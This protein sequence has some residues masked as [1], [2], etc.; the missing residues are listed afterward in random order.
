MEM[1]GISEDDAIRV[2]A[3]SMSGCSDCGGSLDSIRRK[4]NGK[5]I[6]IKHLRMLELC[7]N[8]HFD[9]TGGET[10]ELLA[11][12]SYESKRKQLQIS[13]SN[14]LIERLFR[15]DKIVIAEYNNFEL[16]AAWV[17]DFKTIADEIRR[18]SKGRSSWVTKLSAKWAKDNGKMVVIVRNAGRKDI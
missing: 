4:L 5:P 9:M 16:V 14:D 18:Q 11:F 2:I 13:S 10:I 8:T 1:M 15:A 7:D 3:S 12:D 17:I 6:S